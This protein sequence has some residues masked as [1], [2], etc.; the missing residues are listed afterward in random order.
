MPW[1]RV[2]HEKALI[3]N[4]R[5][6]MMGSYNWSKGAAPTSE[7]LNVVTSPEVGQMYARHWQARQALSIRFTD[8]SQW[9][10]R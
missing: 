6:M 4:R 9:R 1:A 3:I 2:A 10:R 8:A 7:F 5:V